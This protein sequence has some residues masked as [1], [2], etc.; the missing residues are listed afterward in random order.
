MF[1]WAARQVIQI[2]VED[3]LMTLASTV[4]R[5]VE[6]SETRKILE[7]ESILGESEDWRPEF[8]RTLKNRGLRR[9]CPRFAPKSRF[10]G[11][12]P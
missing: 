5:V 6:T 8:F 2:E 10:R 9:V 1:E 7:V 3:R 11:S 4:A 12:M